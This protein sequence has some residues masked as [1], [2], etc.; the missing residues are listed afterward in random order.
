MLEREGIMFAA[1]PLLEGDDVAPRERPGLIAIR[2]DSLEEARCIADADPMHTSGTR[3]YTIRG[4][5]INEG[6]INVAI[7][8]S[9]QNRSEIN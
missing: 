6:S 7:K 8:L 9:G 4:W 3:N 1:G 5:R 2:A